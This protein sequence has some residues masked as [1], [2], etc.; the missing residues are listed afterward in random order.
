MKI[1]P[2]FSLISDRAKNIA[3]MEMSH[4]CMT[5]NAETGKVDEENMTFDPVLGQKED[6][7]FSQHVTY[8]TS[9]GAGTRLAICF[10]VLILI[11]PFCIVMLSIELDKIPAS[12][13]SICIGLFAALCFYLMLALF[14]APSCI[15]RDSSTSISIRV[16]PCNV[17]VTRMSVANISK[18][19]RI[20]V[21]DLFRLKFMGF[22]T[23]LHRLVAIELNS[24]RI[25]VVSLKEP[26][27]FVRDVNSMV[28]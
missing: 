22:P 28:Q 3:H 10:W 7:C 11:L 18:T 24:G 13:F 4:P 8:P 9:F 2:E 26:D 6:P 19:R 1:L 23:D 25:I 5:L 20:E 17:E 16:S 27:R 21:R 14:A 12:M 15:I